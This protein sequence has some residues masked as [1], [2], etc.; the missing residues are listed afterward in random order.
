MEHRQ[1]FF[2]DVPNENVIHSLNVCIG[3]NITQRYNLDKDVLFVKTTIKLVEDEMAKGVKL[4]KIFPPG[5]TTEVTYLQALT[6]LNS[7]EF[8]EPIEL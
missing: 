7:P 6:R 2:I 3:L 1:Y 8:T 4:N 5:L